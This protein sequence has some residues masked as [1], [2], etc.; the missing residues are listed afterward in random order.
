MAGHNSSRK[1][2]KTLKAVPDK[3]FGTLLRLVFEEG[4]VVPEKLSGLYKSHK[5]A[6]VAIDYYNKGYDRPKIYP[7]APKNDIPQRRVT[8]NAKDKNI[9]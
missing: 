1:P 3:Q 2:L 4:G 7:K 5:T 8:Q 6:Q 9:S